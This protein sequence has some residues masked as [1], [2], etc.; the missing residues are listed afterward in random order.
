MEIEVR[1][2]KAKGD[3]RG[4]CYNQKVEAYGKYT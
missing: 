3:E 4:T 2:G 1:R